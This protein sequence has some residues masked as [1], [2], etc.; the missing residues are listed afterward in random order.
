MKKILLSLISAGLLMSL[1]A[2]EKPMQ[3]KCMCEQNEKGCKHRK[4]DKLSIEDIK[5][6]V[7]EKIAFKEKNI[8]AEKECLT[9]NVKEELVSCLHQ[10]K[11]NKKEFKR[12][13]KGM[14]CEKPQKE[15]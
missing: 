11:E 2:N 4:L 6:H 1:S 15:D 5:K 8:A 7:S 14:K 13:H 3:E 10:I 9:K 12:E